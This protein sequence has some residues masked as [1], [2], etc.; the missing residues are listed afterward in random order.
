MKWPFRSYK[1]ELIATQTDLIAM[2]QRQNDE[3]K[4]L[5]DM[6]SNFEIVDQTEQGVTLK[7]KPLAG[8]LQTQIP[9]RAGFRGRVAAGE[10]KTVP[11]PNDS[12]RALEK[13]VA[14]AKLHQEI[15]KRMAD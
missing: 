7:M 15:Q 11:V 13:R 6:R 5:F 9:G 3:L 14:E 10:A 12:V 1:D 2:L 4:A 8:G